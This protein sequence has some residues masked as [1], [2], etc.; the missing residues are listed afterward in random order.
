MPNSER[1]PR[2]ARAVFSK[3]ASVLG[4]EYEIPE[5]KS[6]NGA[7]APGRF[8]EDL[9]GVDENNRDSPDLEDWE[10]KFT[11]G[12]SLLTL[13]HKDPEPRGIMRLLVHTHG[14]EDDKGRISFR[15]TMKGR[16]PRGLYIVNEV[17]RI[18]V[19]HETV[20]TV[21]PHWK[22][23]TIMCA[24]G[25]KLRRLILVRGELKK[26]P[27]RV[28]YNSAEGFW[29]FRINEF[30]QALEQ[31]IIHLDFDART[32]KGRGTALRNHGTKFRIKPDDLF[33]FY[34]SRKKITT[35]MG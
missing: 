33:K 31:G 11:G 34:H 30:C 28:I 7:G 12:K 29:D 9:L 22:H 2:S 27:R 32:Q 20:D 4:Q 24:V 23:D 10:L 17:D 8:L 16:S 13:F 26:N 21:V 1:L 35:R 19:R 18:V 14:W 25:A 6:Y 15:H 5:K 3:V